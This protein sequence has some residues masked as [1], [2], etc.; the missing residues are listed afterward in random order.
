[1]LLSIVSPAFG[2]PRGVVGHH[3]EKGVGATLPFVGGHLVHRR[4]KVAKTSVR[5]LAEGRN[6]HH[7]FGPENIYVDAES[8]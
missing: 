5:E 6:I 1:M 7:S 2:M 8:I 4:R 3:P